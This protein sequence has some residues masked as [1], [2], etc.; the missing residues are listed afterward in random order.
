MQLV[1]LDEELVALVFAALAPVDYQRAPSATASLE[2]L[3]VCDH[4]LVRR[5]HHVASQWTSVYAWHIHQM[6][7]N[8][9]ATQG[10]APVNHHMQL[11]RP[12]GQLACPVAHH[13][14]GTNHEKRKLSLIGE[15]IGK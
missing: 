13:A 2:F 10:T 4:Q 15:Q 6:F 1:Q 3:C 8:Q 12:L 14:V 11:R 9:L 5:N 7:P